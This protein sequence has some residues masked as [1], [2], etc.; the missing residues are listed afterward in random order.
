MSEWLSNIIQDFVCL[1]VYGAMVE[2]LYDKTHMRTMTEAQAMREVK[3]WFA[4]SPRVR[5]AF[6]RRTCGR[7]WLALVT[8]MCEQNRI[9]AS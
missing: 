2:R 7:P 5:S 8:E 3:A 6:I 1:M 9:S 4:A